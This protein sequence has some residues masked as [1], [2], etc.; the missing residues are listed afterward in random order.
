[1]E[2]GK[3][4]VKPPLFSDNMILYEKKFKNPFKKSIGT[5]AQISNFVIYKI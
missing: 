5:N 4:E 3:E 2:I 1:M